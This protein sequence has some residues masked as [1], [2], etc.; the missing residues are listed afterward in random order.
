MIVPLARLLEVST[1][2]LLGMKNGS[3]GRQEELRRLWK[4]TWSTGDTAKR[5]EISRTAVEEYPGN[6]EYLIWLADAEVFFAIHNCGAHTE[7]RNIHFE[8]AVKYYEMVIADCTDTEMRNDAIYGIVMTLPDVGRREEAVAYAKMHPRADE[9][10][11]WCLTGE[12]KEQCRQ[13]LIHGCMNRLVGWLEFGKQDLASIKAAETIVKTIISDGNYL[14]HNDTLMHNYIWQAM[15]LTRDGRFDEAID[16]LKTSYQYAAAYMAVFSQAKKQPIAYTCPILNRLY[17][18][19][20]DMSIS[21]MTS[22]IDDFKD[23]LI[24]KEFDELRERED[25]KVLFDF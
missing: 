10:L 14:Y 3:D 24:G 9:L 11:M 2:E 21:G 16:A 1:D 4:E 20:N 7:D 5:Y 22:L 25:F 12:E 13:R 8:T 23:Y 6:F 17:F 19:G 18:D 15:C